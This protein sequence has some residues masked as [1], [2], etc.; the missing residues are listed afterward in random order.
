MHISKLNPNLEASLTTLGNLLEGDIFI[1]ETNRILYATDASVYREIP[2]GVA[3]PKNKFD[4]IKLVQFADES[5]VSLIPRSAGTSLAGQC[6]GDGLVVDVS[7][8][9]TKI[10]SLDKGNKKVTVQPGVN[11]D[12][13]NRFL[14]KEG[15]FFGPNTS[16]ANRCLIG[17]MVGNNSSGTTSI[18]YGTTRE[19]VEELEVVLANGS[20]VRVND[21]TLSNNKKYTKITEQLTALLSKKE[22][23][24]NIHDKFP[25]PEI[26]R[27]NTGYALDEILKQQPF[28]ENGKPL[29]LSKLLT[30]SEG[31]L[32]FTTEITL[33]LDDLPPSN[34]MVVCPHFESIRESMEATV[35]TMQESPFACEL[36]DK[37]ILDCT[38]ENKE[39]A[40]NRAFVEGDPQA[41]LMVEFRDND[42]LV[43]KEKV[44]NYIKTLKKENFGYAYPIIEGKNVPKVWQLRAAGLGVLANLP[45]D[46][47][48]VACIED[49]AV[50]VDDLANYIDEF[51]EMMDSFGQESV[52]YA[53]AGAGEIHL[54]PI[55]D[56]KKASDVKLF[57][58][59]SKASALLVAKYKG[60]LSGE[61]GDGRVRA[62]FIPLVLGEENYQTLKKVKSIF[63]PKNIFNPG[64]IV[65][66]APMDSSLRYEP[67][68]ETKKFNTYFDF[69]N[70][71]GI[72]RAAEKCNGSGDCRKSPE[73]GGVMC[74]SF[75]ATRVEKDTTR[76]RA[77]VLREFL[78]KSEIPF[79]SEEVK[80]VLDL[81][82]SCK[83]CQSECPSNV[84]MAAMKAE[85]MHNY[86]QAKGIP[87]RTK[88]IADFAKF[89]SLAYPLAGIYNKV[90][91]NKFI[92]K[93]IK[94]TIGFHKDRSLPTL[95]K[96]SVKDWFHKYYCPP[97]HPIK[98]VYLFVD[99]FINWN[100]SHIGIEGIQLLTHL[101]Y[102][103][104][105]VD[106][107]KQSGRTYLS[108][109]ILDKAKDLAE[110]NVKTYQSII[111]AQTP[112]LGI[113]PSA[114]LTFKDEYP[115]LVAEVLKPAA[116]NIATNT[117]LIETFLKKEFEL[118][119]IQSGQFDNKNR[120]LIYHAHCH[121]KA[122]VGKEDAIFSMNIPENHLVEYIDTGCCGMAGSFGFEEEHYEVSQRIANIKLFP[123]LKKIDHKETIIVASGVSCRHQIKDGINTKA[124]H[125]ISILYQSVLK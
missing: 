58:Q 33:S 119:N 3:Y 82:L 28:N 7:K 64:K 121:Q 97:T 21:N 62:P 113:E 103:V 101:N 100:E 50:R 25:H 81:C 29:N 8:Y 91:G 44:V 5:G 30:G 116:K 93:S 102:E 15:L 92:A 68:Q 2:L 115:R 35:I 125:P 84:D 94:K 86:H 22:V 71:G 10:I 70:V 48:A 108:K 49:T 41:I 99:E 9:M 55:L 124:I 66:A 123:T 18:K 40:Q 106:N 52:Y 36:M 80:S 79:E 59:I 6:V 95:S 98:K 118:G 120:K 39:Q 38:K 45:G 89:Q 46:K 122:Q 54:R 34:V 74:P 32:A 90:I 16:T 53:H 67:E 107:D 96:I 17:G 47:K 78:T 37:I 112:L 13:L 65:D 69:S 61:H 56:L 12:N 72:I 24:Q 31:T 43:L 110:H 4:V 23:Q 60:A 57:Y 88:M 85:F 19:H 26:H 83:A 1:D 111:S 104:I 51:S 117:H 42:I 77:N 75:H 63:D 105:I 76:A 109:G 20:L 87:F 11:R 73:A 114:I 27:R 14:A